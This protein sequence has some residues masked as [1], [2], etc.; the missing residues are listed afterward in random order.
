MYICA[1]CVCSNS[2]D[3]GKGTKAKSYLPKEKQFLVTRNVPCLKRADSGDGTSIPEE[4][5]AVDGDDDAW[6]AP[7]SQVSEED[8][9][10]LQEIGEPVPQP[11]ATMESAGC[12]AQS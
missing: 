6:V 4:L 8:K 9:E 2:R 12:N 11:A 7:Q 10:E 5:L 1:L 3:A